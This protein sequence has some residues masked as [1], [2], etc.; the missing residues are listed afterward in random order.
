MTG[1]EWAKTISSHGVVCCMSVGIG[2]A[3]TI[4][5]HGVARRMTAGIGQAKTISS[6]YLAR[7]SAETSKL[8][9]DCDI[10][11]LLSDDYFVVQQQSNLVLCNVKAHDCSQAGKAVK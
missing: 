5:S 2:Q 6:H 3:E 1:I 7:I 8:D 9:I 10:I 11:Q 4:S